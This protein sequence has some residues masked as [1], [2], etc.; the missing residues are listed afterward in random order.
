MD[1]SLPSLDEKIEAARRRAHHYAR[2]RGWDLEASK[3][4]AQFYI[5]EIYAN[6]SRGTNEQIYCY[7]IRGRNG[8]VGS[9]KRNMR[10]A[11]LRNDSWA[12]GLR[13]GEEPLR[14]RTDFV[15]KFVSTP[16]Q[17]PSFRES[18]SYQEMALDEKISATLLLN[19]FSWDDI[20]KVFFPGSGSA[21]Y[22]FKQNVLSR[23]LDRA[24]REGSSLDLSTLKAPSGRGQYR[25]SFVGVLHQRE[26]ERKWQERQEKRKTAK[27][28]FG[29]DDPT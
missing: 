8:E 28:L 23:W 10:L 20:A 3:D 27:C 13:D 11:L 26:D 21:F 5:T 25:H 2:R 19:G 6:H 12:R 17:E 1:S 9:S 24:E 18:R 22:K 15:E 7:W 29:L 16:E 14:S 4:F